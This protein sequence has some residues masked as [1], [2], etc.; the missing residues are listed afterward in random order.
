MAHEVKTAP[1]GEDPV[2]Y[3]AALPTARR[4]AEGARLLALFGEATG[5]PPVMWGPSMIGYGSQDHTYASGRGGTWFRVGF[6]PRKAAISLYGLQDAP[7]AQALLD[8]LGKH[9][10]AVGC[11]YV[12]GL[13]DV[14]EEVLR[15]LVAHAWDSP[16]AS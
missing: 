7:G 9:R 13:A 6:S 1:T 3:C 16:P 10:R 5:A 15:A 2:A 14:D 4:R 11:V 12:N 8:R